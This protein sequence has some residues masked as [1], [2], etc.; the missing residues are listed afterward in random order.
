MRRWLPVLLCLF[1]LI[2]Q[3]AGW[4]YYIESQR[5]ALAQARE[6]YIS[7]R[8]RTGGKGVEFLKAQYDYEKAFDSRRQ[9]DVLL[10]I[11]SSAFAILLVGAIVRAFRKQ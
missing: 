3:G 2:A 7:L 8:E 6:P 1:M 11:S 10:I 5:T 4:L 9:A